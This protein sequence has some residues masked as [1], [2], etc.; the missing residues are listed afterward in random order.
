MAETFQMKDGLGSAAI[1]RIRAAVTAVCPTFP[2]DAFAKAANQRIGPLE[3][4]QRLNQIIHLIHEHN[5]LSDAELIHR[6]GDIPDLWD[7]GDENDNTA[8]FAAW[9]II[10]YLSVYG[11]DQPNES[12]EVMGKITCLF[13]AEFA[14]RPFLQDHES[15]TKQ[16]LDR[17]VLSSDPHQRRL[18]S[19]GT[20]ISLPWGP[21]LTIHKPQPDR[22]LS[23]LIQLKDDPDEV[24][25]RSV[26]NH[27]NDLSKKRPDLVISLCGDWTNGAS[28]ERLKLIRHACRSLIKAGH[29]AVFPLFGYSDSRL[30][31]IHFEVTPHAIYLGESVNLRL[32]AVSS[33]QNHLVVDYA[34]YFVGAHQSERRKVFKWTEIRARSGDVVDMQKRHLFKPIT[35]RRYYSGLHRVELLI[36]GSAVA[37]DTFQLHT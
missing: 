34:V 23:Y 35:T 36:N 17:W 16:W 33:G 28:P 26:A 7:A 29:P 19:E 32:Q 18:V 2:G 6:F 22:Y 25:R 12:L 4:K 8:R 5:P 11:L 13:T 30:K 27:L 10:D 31:D 1:E 3:L 9:P 15:L 20:R 37:L 24:V 14:I 21:N